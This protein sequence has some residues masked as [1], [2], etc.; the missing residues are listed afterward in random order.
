MILYIQFGFALVDIESPGRVYIY[1]YIR[2]CS[3]KTVA[4]VRR[5]EKVIIFDYHSI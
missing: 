2:E 4:T 1:F 5:T 3:C